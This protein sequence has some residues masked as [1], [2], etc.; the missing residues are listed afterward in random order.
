[1]PFFAQISKVQYFISTIKPIFQHFINILHKF[2]THVAFVAYSIVKS[3]LH[4]TILQRFTIFPGFRNTLIFNQIKIQSTGATKK[5]VQ[6]MKTEKDKKNF[7]GT[8]DIK[9]SITS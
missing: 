4:D 5:V 9:I 2:I 1:M 8:S 3:F 7:D 6:K